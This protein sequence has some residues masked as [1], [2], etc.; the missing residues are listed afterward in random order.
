MRHS[1]SALLFIAVLSCGCDTN[2][3]SLDELLLKSSPEGAQT[4]Y[5]IGLPYEEVFFETNG[6]KRL[7]GWFI[8]SVSGSNRATVLI[9]TGM[10]GNMEEYL[11]MFP[12]FADHGL[13]TFIYDWQGFGNSEGQRL[14]I[15]FE[16]D[17]YSAVD[18]LVARPDPAAKAIIHFGVSL[19]SATALGAAAHSPDTTIGVVVYGA[20]EPASLPADYIASQISPLLAPTGVVYGAVFSQWATPF[21]SPQ[22]HIDGVKAP[23]LAV[24]ARDDQAI[25]PE[26]QLQLYNQD[27][28]PKAIV[29]TFGGHIASHRTDPDLGTK[30]LEWIDGLNGILA[31]D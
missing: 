3:G 14:F 15:N 30:I 6:G 12:W 8:P 13:N 31:I 18:Y 16:A 11:P 7:A 1:I 5:T 24:I 17:T 20:F 27:P 22:T 19:G 10:Q 4:P 26:I 28:E 2:V 23:I 21:L 9:H 29:Y 25:L